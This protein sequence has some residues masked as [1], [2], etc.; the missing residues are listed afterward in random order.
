M[1]DLYIWFKSRRCG[2]L[3]TWFCYQMIAKPGY[4]TAAPS[5]PDPYVYTNILSR[6]YSSL[7][8]QMISYIQIYIMYI[9]QVP[10]LYIYIYIHIYNE[11]SLFITEAAA[12]TA[13]EVAS[14]SAGAVLAGS[15]IYFRQ[16]CLVINDSVSPLCTGWCHLKLPTTLSK[17]SRHF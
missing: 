14:P 11:P 4:Q 7:C 9:I 2:C 16:S 1:L 17:F 5:W 8:L 6:V 13:P 10:D 12:A 3:V 15:Y